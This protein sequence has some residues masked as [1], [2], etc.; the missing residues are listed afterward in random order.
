MNMSDIKRNVDA[1]GPEKDPLADLATVE[2]EPSSGP[3]GNSTASEQPESV[4][5][6]FKGK[7]VDE[8]LSSYSHLE[9]EKG[10]LAQELGEL[11]KVTDEWIKST[12]NPTNPNAPAPNGATSEGASSTSGKTKYTL[13]DFDRNP[14]EVVEA[15]IEERTKP[16]TSAL[17]K[18]QEERERETF[19]D[20]YPKAN[21]IIQDPKFQEW[22]QRSENRL[23]AW[24]AARQA[25]NWDAI[26]AFMDSWN[27]LTE[28]S[29]SPANNAAKVQDAQVTTDG[30]VSGVSTVGKK[31]IRRSDLIELNMKDPN[32]YQALLPEI[33]KA[34]AEGRVID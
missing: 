32:R 16:L 19:F 4:P 25:N 13:D 10:R 3:N 18:T 22:V 27:D 14:L 33:R 15:I 28:V 11:R 26:G 29:S 31:K 8:I 7:S 1:T 34:Y 20:Q 5:E 17:A 12:L 6:K 9:K 21:E 30:V 23:N 2:P 24:A